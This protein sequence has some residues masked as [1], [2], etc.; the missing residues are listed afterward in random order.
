MKSA[1]VSASVNYN[2]MAFLAIFVK[3]MVGNPGGGGDRS[4]DDHTHVGQITDS[5]L[6]L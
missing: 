4:G 5:H 2:K 6:M 3:T 1:S